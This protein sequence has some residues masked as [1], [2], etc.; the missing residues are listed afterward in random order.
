MASTAG[1]VELANR[2]WT[3][4]P[5]VENLEDPLAARALT[6]RAHLPCE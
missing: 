4:E 6:R 3:L 1:E 5:G 2:S